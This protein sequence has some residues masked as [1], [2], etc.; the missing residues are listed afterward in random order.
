MK[1]FGAL[2]F[3]SSTLIAQQK[4]APGD[5]AAL[6]YYAAFSVMQDAAVSD[7]EAR[8]LIGILDGLVPYD[9]SQYETLVEQNRPAL[10]LMRLGVTH[11]TCDWGL[12]YQLK[13][14][15]PVD[16]ARRA[17]QLGR[18]N[19]L[20]AFHLSLVGDKDGAVRTLAAGIH[21]SRDVANG[22]SLF[23]TLVAKQLLIE[24]LR[25]A[26]G[27]VQLANLSPAQRSL[28]RDAVMQAETND[29]DWQLAIQ[30]EF[31]AIGRPDQQ[32]ALRQ[33]AEE[34]GATLKDPASLG[35]LEASISKLLPDL[36]QLIPIP[37]RVINEKQELAGQIQRARLA[38]Q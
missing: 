32:T 35:R 12:D 37:K 25:A 11:A 13:D 5:N 23:A 24:H 28:L 31:M 36:Q 21:F 6:R 38:T 7:A 17:L 22:G 33:V 2:L 19:V 15:V 14:K 1:W 26:G 3:V 34:Y 4:P 27:L 16:Y 10:A 30:R 18:L 29:L 8:K 9:D 20:Y